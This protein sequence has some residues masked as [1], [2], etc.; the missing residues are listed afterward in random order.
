MKNNQ[1]ASSTQV[2]EKYLLLWLCEEKTYKV[3]EEKRYAFVEEVTLSKKTRG[4]VLG[5]FRGPGLPEQWLRNVE[6]K[7]SIN[8]EIKQAMVDFLNQIKD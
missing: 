5:S 7:F 4:L 2:G 6:N 1:P 8:H 3:V